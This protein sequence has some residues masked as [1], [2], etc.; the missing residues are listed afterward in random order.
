MRVVGGGKFLK[1]FTL[2][3]VAVNEGENYRKL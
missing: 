2:A 1:E 3:S